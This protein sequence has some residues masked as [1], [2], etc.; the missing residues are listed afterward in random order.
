[1]TQGNRALLEKLTE[2]KLTQGNRALL[3]KL[4]EAKLT[5]GNRALLEKLTE[6]NKSSA[7]QELPFI[8]WNAVFSLLSLKQPA[9]CPSPEPDKSNQP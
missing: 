8:L 4:T 2:A 6:A 3:E 9:T 1:L 5:Q 7:S